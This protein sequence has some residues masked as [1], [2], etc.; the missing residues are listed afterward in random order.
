[1]ERAVGARSSILIGSILAKSPLPSSTS[2]SAGSTE[3]DCKSLYESYVDGIESLVVSAAQRVGATAYAEVF[4]RVRD[5][6]PS[7]LRGDGMAVAVQVIDAT[8]DAGME[9]QWQ[10]IERQLHGLEEA[11]D[12][13]WD[14][15]L[16]Y[17]EANP[18]EFFRE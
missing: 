8:D 16:R 14:R 4:S 3:T 15:M 11:G 1:M 10:S 13:I 17:I 9:Q 7:G 12:L 2:P 5:L 6:L 18:H